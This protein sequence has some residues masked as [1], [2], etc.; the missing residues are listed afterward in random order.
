MFEVLLLRSLLVDAGLSN[1]VETPTEDKD[2]GNWDG[3]LAVG[4]LGV[5][6]EKGKECWEWAAIAHEGGRLVGNGER[7]RVCQRMETSP[8]TIRI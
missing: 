8:K 6:L 2:E 5:E 3:L 4:V 1:L 7:S